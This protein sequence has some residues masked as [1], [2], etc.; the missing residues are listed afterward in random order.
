VVRGTIDPLNVYLI[1][2]IG[3]DTIPCVDFDIEASIRIGKPP[4]AVRMFRLAQYLYVH[5][6]GRSVDRV[7]RKQTKMSIFYVDEGECVDC[8]CS[9]I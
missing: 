3:F 7:S 8:R 9:L 4:L 1:A 5:M 2:V 6:S